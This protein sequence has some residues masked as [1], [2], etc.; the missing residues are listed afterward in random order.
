MVGVA[1]AHEGGLRADRVRGPRRRGGAARSARPLAELPALVAPDSFKGTFSAREV[2]ARG[3]ARAA[4][5]GP[6]RRRSC[7][8]PTAARGRWTRCCRRSRGERARARGATR[9]AAPVEAALRTDRRRANGDRRDGAGERARPGRRGRARRLG[10]LHAR[11]RRADR[12]RG[13][14]GRRAGD[15]DG[16][17]ARRRRTAAPAPSRRS[18]EAGVT[19]EMDVL[20]D[21]R[22]PFEDAARVFGPQKGADAAHGAQADR[23]ARRAGG[24]AARATR[25][26]CR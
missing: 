20:C 6:R 18:T 3:G 16:R 21:V 26:A 13:R 5:R 12:R 14:G 4:L 19:V 22:T 1:R 11:D 17:A 23:A 9:S 25:A 10:G 24:A 15:R 2:A 7:R 8:W